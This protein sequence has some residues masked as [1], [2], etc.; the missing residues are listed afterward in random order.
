MRVF[1]AIAISAM[2]SAGS[3]AA[4][5]VGFEGFAS[6]DP[7][8]AIL[9]GDGTSATV[10]TDSNRPGANGGLDQAFA[11][12]TNNFTGNDTDLVSSFTNASDPGITKDLGIVA[13]IGGPGG[14]APGSAAPTPNDEARGGTITF[15][16]D[17]LVDVLS[18]DY[19]D[20][21]AGGNELNV[22]AFDDNGL[23]G[24]SGALVAGDGQF[25]T[26]TA[27]FLGVRSLV[28]NFGG[29]GALDNIKITPVPLPA[30]LPLLAGGLGILGFLG[31]RRRQ[32]V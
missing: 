4:S 10:V 22:S 8:N 5:T 29:S 19:V 3:A 31:W 1:S 14:S 18:F 27:G 7:I 30:A 32:R 9:F 26:F 12:D 13:V 23:I 21:E 2:L 25:D 15:T 17:R 28:F 6:D 24:T 11:F 20:T 16:F